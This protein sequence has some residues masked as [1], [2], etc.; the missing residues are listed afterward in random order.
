[1]LRT[2]QLHGS[3]AGCMLAASPPQ[4]IAHSSPTLLPVCCCS[5]VA[6]PWVPRA[7]PAA[8]RRGAGGPV[9]GLQ[10]PGQL[11]QPQ[12]VLQAADQDGGMGS[13][14]GAARAPPRCSSSLGCVRLH[15]SLSA[16]ARPSLLLLGSPLYAPLPA[17]LSAYLSASSP[18][19]PYPSP[20]RPIPRSPQAVPALTPP[21]ALLHDHFG[22]FDVLPQ[23]RSDFNFTE[24]SPVLQN[25]LR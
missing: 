24:A 25:A 7:G 18:P 14:R 9:R 8:A 15:A 10:L 6:S 16:S 23:R 17:C 2:E 11:P 12:Q 19:L 5:P 22:D 3:N 21:E 4:H 1:M 20:R 13:R